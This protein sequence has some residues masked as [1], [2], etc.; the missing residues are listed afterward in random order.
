[1]S[2]RG[3]LPRG[4]GCVYPGVSARGCLPRGVRPGG[5]CL[6]GVCPSACW[7]TYRHSVWT[8]FLT[9]ACENY[10]ADGKY[11][12]NCVSTDLVQIYN[13]L[14]NLCDNYIYYLY[15]SQNLI[16]SKHKL[17]LCNPYIFNLNLI[18]SYKSVSRMQ[19]GGTALADPRGAPGTRAPPGGP[20]SF[21]FMQFSAKIIN[22]HTHFG[23]WRPP[24][25]N[26][27][28]A[29]GKCYHLISHYRQG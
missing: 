19:M 12:N 13:M 29:T 6:G 8:E 5:V 9:H 18:T 23:S 7:D 11:L 24:G 16:L 17:N 25:E 26:P 4:K 28:S 14:I 15:L 2:A 20:N 10:V 27:R 21:I 3:C 22:K 1:M